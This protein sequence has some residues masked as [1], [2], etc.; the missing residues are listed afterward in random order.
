M[1]PAAAAFSDE[2]TESLV[3]DQVLDTVAVENGGRYGD[4]RSEQRQKLEIMI[5][6]PCS[7]LSAKELA[8][9][10]IHEMG[11]IDTHS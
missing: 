7:P 3:G 9:L 5:H 8:V 1:G 2:F 6:E 4:S 11:K 10:N